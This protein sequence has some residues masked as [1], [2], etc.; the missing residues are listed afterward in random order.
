MMKNLFAL[1]LAATVK[2]APAGDLVTEIPG[3][4]NFTEFKLYS[5]YVTGR[6]D[7]K[8]DPLVNLH[9]VLAESQDDPTTDPLLIW[10]NGGPGCSSMLGFSQE[11]G[12]YV[13]E[14]G[15]DNFVW[16]D[17][18]WN[19]NANVLYLEMPGGVGYSYTKTPD[20]ENFTDT[21]TSEDNLR[22]FLDWFENKFPE[23]QNHDLYVSGESYAGVYVP[24]MVLQMDRHNEAAK[25][26]DFKFNLKGF[27]VG[28][29][30]TNWKWDGDQAYIVGGFPRGL[31]S[32]NMQRDQMN[33]NCNYYY[34]DNDP[35]NTPVCDQI[36]N[37][38]YEDTG[39]INVY[40]IYR[41]CWTV[42]D[43]SSTPTLTHGSV[44][45]NGEEKQYRRHFG[46]KDYTPWVYEKAR[47]H[48]MVSAGDCTWDSPVTDHF[49]NKTV[50]AAMHIPDEAGVWQ[51]CSDTV[52]YESGHNASEWI[53]PLMRHK[54]RILHYS[55]DTDGAVPTEGTQTW[56]HQMG[57]EITDPWRPYY[58]DN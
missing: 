31:S 12:P 38:F 21:T 54:Y 33:N 5:G 1:G 26:S 43:T 7:S 39:S 42:N 29:G 36:S 19:T 53:Y 40:D 24:Y 20:L 50:R 55:G 46:S 3:M 14:D 17:Y 10:F 35:D 13:N 58:Y 22:G 56:M 4:G 49:N 27:I 30:V 9:Y 41:T 18:S 28:N 32:L 15:T 25:D 11:H 48:P 16:N 51:E 34:E 6:S 44:E 23:Y 47:S 2:A 37:K 52:I 57:W 8:G 45:L